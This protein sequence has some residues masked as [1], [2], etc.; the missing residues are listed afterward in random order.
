[1]QNSIAQKNSIQYT[2]FTTRDFY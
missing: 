1:M 2:S